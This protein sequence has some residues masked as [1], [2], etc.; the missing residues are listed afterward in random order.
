[1]D[2]PIDKI[3][4]F[5][6]NPGK[7][8]FQNIFTRIVP[9]FLKEFLQGNPCNLIFLI[10]S[11]F[12]KSFL[13]TYQLIVIFKDNPGNKLDF[14]RIFLQELAMTFKKKKKMFK[15]TPKMSEGLF[16]KFF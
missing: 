11:F 3:A 4:I 5:K 15:A 10:F 7:N 8:L 14:F 9:D 13:K 1:M 2:I 12:F 16:K 6:D